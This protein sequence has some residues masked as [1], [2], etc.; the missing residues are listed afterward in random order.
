MLN[1]TAMFCGSLQPFEK[2]GACAFL[3]PE[4]D[5]TPNRLK[6]HRNV[7]AY[8]E[9]P[10]YIYFSG[11]PDLQKREFDSHQIGDHSY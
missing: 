6:A 7:S 5:I 3:R 4:I 10:A 11:N 1:N 8:S 9:G 2:L